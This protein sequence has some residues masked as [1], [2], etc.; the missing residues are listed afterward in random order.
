MGRLRFLDLEATDTL[1]DLPGPIIRDL[2]NPVRSA[3][4]F[5]D[6]GGGKPQT[7]TTTQNNTPWAPTQPHLTGIMGA[8]KG[9]YDSGV[10][11]KPWEGSALANLSGETQ[12]GLQ[13][14]DEKARSKD[15]LIGES[16]NAARGILTGTPGQNPALKAMMADNAEQVA[17][18]AASKLSG[19]GRYGQNAAFANMLGRNITAANNPLIGAAYESDMARRMGV[20]G[21]APALEELRYSPGRALLDVGAFRDQ[22]G[23]AEHN[24]LISQHNANE[25]RPW[26]QVQRYMGL[27][28]GAGLT[29]GTSVGTQ[30]MPRASLGQSVLGGGLVGGSM[31]GPLGALGGGL[32]GGFLR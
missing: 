31:F 5:G 1:G 2:G 9:L 11:Y 24:N 7:V 8:A 22:R 19:S 13:F 25:A 20:L 28:G 16:L 4:P 12:R 10:G 18:Q 26:E 6:F 30:Q 32:L 23:Q 15:S 29:G 14:I 3:L 27:V 17:N 21:M